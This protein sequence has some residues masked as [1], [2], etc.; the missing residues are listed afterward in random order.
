VVYGVYGDPDV[1][2]N[3][4]ES[5]MPFLIA[6][7]LAGAVVVFGVLAP[8]ALRPGANTGRW[9]LGFSLAGLLSVFAFWSGL[10]VILGAAGILAG[11]TARQDG[12]SSASSWAMSLGALAVVA[13][14]A[15]VVLGNTLLA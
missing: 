11:S 9:G 13:A 10:P 5:S 8:R 3:G 12:V 1:A 2:T 4:Q 15:I 14:I 6:F 7:A